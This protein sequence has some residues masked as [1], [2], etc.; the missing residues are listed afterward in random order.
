MQSARASRDGR[1]RSRRPWSACQMSTS[2]A[3]DPRAPARAKSPER[4]LHIAILYQ[5]Q[6]EGIRIMVVS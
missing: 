5:L 2:A 1:R 4:H 3:L 6:L